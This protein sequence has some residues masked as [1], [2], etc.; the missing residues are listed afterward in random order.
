MNGLL[1]AVITGASQ[2]IGAATARAVAAQHGATAQLILVARNGEKLSRVASD[3]KALGADAVAIPCDVT[4]DA[5]VNELSRAV[6]AGWDAPPSLL[7]N[8]AGAFTPSP[9]SETS[10]D[11]F[12]HQV[13][14][15]LTSAF[16]VTQA[17]LPA[18]IERR[19]GTLVFLASVA[20]IRAYPGSAAY[21]AAKH[22][23]L[24]LARVAREETREHG[25]RVVTIMPGAT[26]TPSWDG[27]DLPASRFM[28]E[29]D[30]ASAILGAHALSRRSVVEEIVMRP[31]LGDI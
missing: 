15:N 13:E 8:N 22:G 17:F 5:E 30:V 23:L 1:R 28:P 11:S 14:T 19:S 21:C 6:M 3:C 25:V 12:R 2:G 4:S 27:T 9:L 7:V 20:S 26:L 10:V 18:M 29:E 31:Q 24:G 16:L